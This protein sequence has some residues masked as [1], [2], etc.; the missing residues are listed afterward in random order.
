MFKSESEVLLD[1][2]AGFLN[3][4]DCIIYMTPKTF[5]ETEGITEKTL[6]GK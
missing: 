6:K 4:T 1:M 5:V 2:N 3:G